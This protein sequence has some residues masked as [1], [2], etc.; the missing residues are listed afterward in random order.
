MVP[1]FELGVNAFGDKFKKKVIEDF[2]SIGYKIE[3]IYVAPYEIYN[4]DIHGIPI[5]NILY[6][7]EQNVSDKISHVITSYSIHYTKLYEPVGLDGLLMTKMRVLGVMA[8][9]SCCGVILKRV[10]TP[11]R[12]MTGSASARRTMS[13]YVITS[14]SIHYTKLYDGNTCCIFIVTIR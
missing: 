12:T 2:N 8:A 5:P 4:S 6:I 10:S 1:K 3:D 7:V 11:A 9:S 13:G 14:Y